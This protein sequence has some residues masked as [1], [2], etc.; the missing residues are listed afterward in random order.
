MCDAVCAHDLCGM[1]L[2]PGAGANYECPRFSSP[3]A[4]RLFKSYQCPSNQ[5]YPTEALT[6]VRLNLLVKGPILDYLF[7]PH[8]TNE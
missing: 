7:Q 6:V 3:E 5:K 2:E 1:Q 8:I 4:V